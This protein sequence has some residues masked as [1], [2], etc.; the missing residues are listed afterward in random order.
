MH[1]C[2]LIDGSISIKVTFGVLCFAQFILLKNKNKC[3]LCNIV[4][5]NTTYSDSFY[6]MTIFVLWCD[7]LSYGV[8]NIKQQKNI[9]ILK[10]L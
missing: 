10:Y 3:P 2:F 6:A 7:I 5:I 1:Q 8:T 9:L 4:T